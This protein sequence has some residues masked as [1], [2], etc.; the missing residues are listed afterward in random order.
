MAADIQPLA[1][2]V[3][4]REFTEIAVPA[5]GYSHLRLLAEGLTNQYA[6]RQL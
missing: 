6:W 3:Q 4:T 2:K 1:D 5:G